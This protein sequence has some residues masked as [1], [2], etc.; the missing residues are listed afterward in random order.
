[1]KCDIVLDTDEGPEQI[2]RHQTKHVAKPVT[3]Q[4]G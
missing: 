4:K 1:M 2:L 3:K